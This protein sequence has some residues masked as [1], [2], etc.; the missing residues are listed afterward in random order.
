[1]ACR[2]L[3]SVSP[4]VRLCHFVPQTI[5]HRK[6]LSSEKFPKLQKR[7]GVP[8]AVFANFGHSEMRVVSYAELQ[9][10]Q[11]DRDE[12]WGKHLLGLNMPF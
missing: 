5:L 6:P 8:L 11:S 3:I 7:Q 2:G 4:Q 10:E 9:G 12:T 1:M